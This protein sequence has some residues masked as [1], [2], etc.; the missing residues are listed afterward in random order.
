ML[1]DISPPPKYK[2]EEGRRSEARPRIVSPPKLKTQETLPK[3]E[4]PKTLVRSKI[5]RF[6]PKIEIADLGSKKG[7][8]PLKTPNPR[9]PDSRDLNQPLN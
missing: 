8:K 3:P 5:D 2:L 4:D 6:R 1:Q 9:K 7:Q